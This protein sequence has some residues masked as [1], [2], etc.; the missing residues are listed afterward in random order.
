MHK[1]DI[2]LAVCSKE[3]KVGQGQKTTVALQLLFHGVYSYE[4]SLQSH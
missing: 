1:L 2:N 4:K 3:G